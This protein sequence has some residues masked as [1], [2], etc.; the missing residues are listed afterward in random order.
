ML[1]DAYPLDFPLGRGCLFP[2]QADLDAVY[3][4]VIDIEDDI[5][6]ISYTLV[7][8]VLRLHCE[9]LDDGLETSQTEVF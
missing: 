9:V 6:S 2:S 4:G 1:T 3:E 7:N 5:G 8:Q